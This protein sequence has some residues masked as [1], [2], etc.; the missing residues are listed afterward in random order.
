[1]F[2]KTSLASTLFVVFFQKCGKMHY[3]HNWVRVPQKS[4]ERYKVAT[5][6]GKNKARM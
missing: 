4:G 5:W 2:G 1:M 6:D 3:T